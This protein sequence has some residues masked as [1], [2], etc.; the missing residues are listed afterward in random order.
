MNGTIT[1]K[2]NHPSRRN[3]KDKKKLYETRN[4]L[5]NYAKDNLI[6]VLAKTWV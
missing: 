6:V 2:T 5:V 4:K 1:L 3:R